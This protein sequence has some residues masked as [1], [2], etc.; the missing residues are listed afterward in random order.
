[1]SLSVQQLN[2]DCTFLFTF[3][4]AC[5]TS[6]RPDLRDHSFNILI[7]PWLAGQSSILHPIF[8]YTKH[9]EKP[10][11]TS[12]ADLKQ[13]LD[14]IIISQ[15]KP[16]H[17]HRETLC[18]LPKSQH[19]NI[20]TTPAAAKKIKSWKCFAEDRIH[21]IP[22]YDAKRD[23][24]S[25]LKIKLLAY[26]S[27]GG[28][29]GE[30]T[31]THLPP[32]RLDLTK[33]HN[34]IAIT[35]RP[36]GTISP[37]LQQQA[38]PEPE[39]AHDLDPPPPST[40]PPTLSILFTPHGLST[41]TLQPYITTHLLPRTTNTSNLTTKPHPPPN[42]ALT[43]LI[44]SLSHD[45]N[46]SCLGGSVVYGAPGGL[47]ILRT[48]RNLDMSVGFWIGAHDGPVERG[49]WSVKWLE[50]RSYGVGE[51]QAWIDGE[52]LGTRV[53]ALESGGVLEVV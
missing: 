47:E 28:A 26:T 25:T 31:I 42:P 45:R 44:H 16:D 33:V 11:I 23:E 7:D 19:V 48:L 36:P 49:G 46:P 34:G 29:E 13:K 53:Q 5:T 21:V 41:T 22:A 32:T 35:Y 40:K 9:T 50:S 10:H 2:S 43:L 51:V 24:E 30:I 8:Q 27:S 37:N 12:L 39:S 3:S 52:G 4:P 17:C 15:D 1:M 6:D 14:L 38:Q 20:L 18:T